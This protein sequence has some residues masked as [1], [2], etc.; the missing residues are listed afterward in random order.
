MSTDTLGRGVHLLPESEVFRKGFGG[1]TFLAVCAEPVTSGPNGDEVNLSYCLN[2]VRA[3]V[4]QVSTDAP[5]PRR[6]RATTHRHRAAI[7]VACVGWPGGHEAP[8]TTVDNPPVAAVERL[9]DLAKEHGFVFTP[10]GED[11]SLWGER[12][13]PQWQDVLFL[14]V[15]GHCN[16]VRSRRGH[17]VAGEPLFTE[18]ITGTALTVLH[19]VLY[20]WPPT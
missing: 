5:H 20:S 2:C 13:G 17:L 10:A 4:A 6:R 1:S 14:G 15:S 7:P 19:E 8:V 16:A 11:G 3:A 9:L 18:R 12:A